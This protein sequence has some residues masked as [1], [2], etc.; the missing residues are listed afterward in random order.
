MTFVTFQL[1]RAYC[2]C[3]DAVGVENPKAQSIN[4]RCPSKPEKKMNRK[5]FKS[6]KY[7]SA[8]KPST[9]SAA[10]DFFIT[11]TAQ[12]HNKK[13]NDN[14]FVKA[15]KSRKPIQKFNKSQEAIAKKIKKPFDKKQWRLK[16]YSNKYKVEEWENKRKE[17]MTRRYNKELKKQ[18]VSFDVQKIYE[19]EVNSDLD[20]EKE[21]QENLNKKKKTSRNFVEAIGDLQE[22]KVK[23]REEAERRRAEKK[24]ALEAY[25]KRKIEK[26]RIL[27]KKTNKGQPIMKGRLELL[28]QQIQ[29]SCGANTQ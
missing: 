11:K 5:P 12:K 9:S 29:E 6:Q 8:E 7:K 21:E 4:F 28:L 24:A 14:F 2:F 10:D 27:S 17:F 19:A 22:D 25:K 15:Q 1:F 18:P 13:P 20:G 23:R 3:C 16:K 26:N